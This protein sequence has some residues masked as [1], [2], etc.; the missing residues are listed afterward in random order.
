[1]NLKGSVQFKILLT[2]ILTVAIVLTTLA[3]LMVENQK[4]IFQSSYRNL[5]VTLAKTLD[6]GI[7]S[8]EDIERSSE[9]QDII[10]KTMWLNPE[11]EEISIAIAENQKLITKASSDTSLIGQEASSK[12]SSVFEK[13][14]VI[15]DNVTSQGKECLEVIAPVHVSGQR[16]G[17]YNVEL[18]LKTLQETTAETRKRFIIGIIIS[19]IAIVIVPSLFIRYS[20]IK[21]IRKLRKAA[22][23]I[24]SGN[25][26]YEI[27]INRSDE[28]GDLAETLDNTKEQLRESTKELERKV[29]ERTEELEEARKVLEIKVK[30]RTRELQKLAERREKI[31]EQRTE[32]LQE[33][34]NELERFRQVAVGRELKM[35]ELK[36]KLRQAQDKIEEL[37]SKL[38]D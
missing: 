24:G 1:M 31:I 7:T 38:K 12:S 35:I 16:M 36:K 6:A 2:V 14:G 10:Y 8:R 29:K 22:K 4:R 9:L 27:N 28:I 33:R 3:F 21:P 30:A 32:E 18:S 37:R 26:D 13:G 20:L 15:T 17:I 34:V 5:G 25:F 19:I 11:V 23:E